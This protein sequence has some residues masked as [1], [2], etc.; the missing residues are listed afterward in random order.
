MSINTTPRELRGKRLFGYSLGDLGFTLP[1]MFTEVFIFQYYVYTIN[2]NALLVSIGVTTQLIIGAIT[3]IIFGVIIDNKNPGKL[4]KRRPFLLIGLPVWFITTILIWFPPLCPQD[5]SLY[6][7]TAFFFWIMTTVRSIFRSLILNVYNS[8]LPEQ[9]QTLKNRERVASIRSAFSILASVLAMFL[10]LFVHSLLSDP[11]HVKWWELSGKIMLLYI[12]LVGILFTIFGLIT[13]I[14]IFFSVDE[15][16]HNRNSNLSNQ[17]TTITEA[18]KR[19]SIPIKDRNF[20]KLI[21]AGFSIWIS[22]KIVALLVF[23][24]Q[25]YLMQFQSSEFFI[26]ILISIFGKFGWFFVWKKILKRNHIVNSYSICILLAVLTSFIDVFFLINGLPYG[27]KLTLYIVSWSTVL[28][29]M[30]AYPLFSMPIMASLVHETAENDK[31]FNVDEAMAKISGSYYGLE[32]FARAL[33][34]AVASLIVG[35]ILSGPNEENPYVIIFLFT[36]LGIFYLIAFLFVK[37]ITLSKDS[38]YNKQIM[39]KDKIH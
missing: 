31:L 10:P 35:S 33:G 14:I 26:Y 2:L 30:Y 29:S 12:P 15:R 7:P 20:I 16:F 32:S 5:N 4:G 38:Y 36:S 1:N 34:P 18:F 25:T 13:V 21:L 3:A 9:S 28:G 17:K 8:M 19:M 22:G 27:I 39:E 37:R 24:F 23:P 6:L 11:A